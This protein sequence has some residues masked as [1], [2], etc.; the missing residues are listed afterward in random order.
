MPNMGQHFQFDTLFQDG[1]T[2]KAERFGDI[3]LYQIG[4]MNCVSG[5]SIPPHVQWCHEI[6]FVIS[7]EGIFGAENSSELLM[8][9]GIQ[10]SPVGTIHSIKTT[11]RDLR[12][13]YMGFTF[14][15]DVEDQ[16][17]LRLKEFF[18]HM[19]NFFAGNCN[20]LFGMFFGALNEL[21]NSDEDSHSMVTMYLHQIL[22]MVYRIL[23]QKKYPSYF[24]EVPSDASSRAI[25]RAVEYIDTHIY[26]KILVKNLSETIGYNYSYLSH[27]FKKGM[28]ITLNGFIANRKIQKGIELMNFENLTFTDIAAKLGYSNVQ[29]FNKAFKRLT[30]STPGAFMKM[31]KKQN[32][33]AGI[34]SDEEATT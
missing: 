16:S 9:G 34:Q 27:A 3:L 13:G 30:G 10:F 5:H 21:H 8:E 2:G 26:E 33:S 29:A 11:N 24:T 12:Y 4:E 18:E 17:I 31:L 19:Q 1:F 23:N 20:Q 14:A 28:G 6:S 32:E 25:F 22:V 15:E 7:G